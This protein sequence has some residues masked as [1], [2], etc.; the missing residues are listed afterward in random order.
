M[1]YT[2][3]CHCGQIAYEVEGEIDALLACN[4]SICSKRGYLLWFVS[5]EKLTLKTPAENMRA[6][7]FNKHQIEH[8]FCPQCG[9]APFG[10]GSD[11]KGNASAAINAR[12]LS[13]IDLSLYSINH[14]DGKSA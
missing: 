5:R 9:C 8:M 3:S 6:Y 10:L 14:Y 11:G 12:C 4:C 2:G 1:T 7:T 13:D